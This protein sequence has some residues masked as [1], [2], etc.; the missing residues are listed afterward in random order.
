MRQGDGLAIMASA[1]YQAGV[2]RGPE[3]IPIDDSTMFGASAKH[4]EIVHIRNWDDEPADRYPN[5]PSRRAGAK[6]ALTIPMV[7]DDVALGVV[8][9]SRLVAGGY[10][11]AEGSLLKTFWIR[12]VAV[13]HA[14]LLIEIEQRNT[15]WLSPGAADRDRRDPRA[16]QRQPGDLRKVFDG[17]VA[18]RH[19][20]AMPTAPQFLGPRVTSSCCRR[21]ATS[22][23]RPTSAATGRRFHER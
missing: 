2:Y 11:D 17:I 22:T 13:D 9:F 15:S 3:V 19:V 7:R 1:G 5:A 23:S 8:A 14:R 6:S 12:T 16:H 10:P 21:R 4:C 18:S 20:S